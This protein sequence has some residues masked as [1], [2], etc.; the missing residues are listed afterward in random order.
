[1]TPKISS[2]LM[3]SVWIYV[4]EWA[5][6]WKWQEQQKFCQNISDS[7]AAFSNLFLSFLYILLEIFR[8]LCLIIEVTK[9]ID[10]FD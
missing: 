2:F 3:Q 1:M 8:T 7:N 9:S 5:N 4:E 10:I 6:R